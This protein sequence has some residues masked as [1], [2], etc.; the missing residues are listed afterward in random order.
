MTRFPRLLPV[1]L[2]AVTAAVLVNNYITWGV[3]TRLSSP[4]VPISLEVT[5][6]Q[7]LTESWYCPDKMKWITVQTCRNPGESLRDFIARHN[8]LVAAMQED[9]PP[10]DPPAASEPPTPGEPR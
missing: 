8:E 5:T 9:C 6:M 4:D 1:V 7:Y 3:H 2:V 10:G